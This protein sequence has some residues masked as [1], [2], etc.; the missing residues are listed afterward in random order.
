MDVTSMEWVLVGGDDVQAADAE[1]VS[2]D[3][4][5]FS[6]HL[7]RLFLIPEEDVHMPA[8]NISDFIRHYENSLAFAG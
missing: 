2:V 5:Y 3:R 4:D 1:I 6:P 7:D 8:D